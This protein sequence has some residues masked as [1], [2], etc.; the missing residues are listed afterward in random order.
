MNYNNFRGNNGNRLVGGGFF[1]PFILG[2]IT[3][4]LLTY[5]PNN[6]GYYYPY[7]PYPYPYPYPY[8]YNQYYY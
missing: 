1:G 2:G 3:G 5:R 4:S 7:Q 8:Q 6:S